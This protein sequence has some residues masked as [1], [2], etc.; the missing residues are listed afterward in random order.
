MAAEPR[1]TA[2]SA[3]LYDR[4]TG[5][6]L[7][8]KESRKQRPPASTTKIMTAVIAIEMGCMG[9]LVTISKNAASV[10]GTSIY[11]RP[12]EVFTVEDLLWGALLNSGNDSCVALAEAVAGSESLFIQM[13][14]KKALLVG[15]YDTTFKNT[16]GLPKD[17]HL[18]TAYDLAKMADYALDN[19]VFAAIVRTKEAEI[20]KKDT[21][22]RRNLNN[23]NRLLSSYKGA[24]GVKTGTTNAAGQCLVASATRNGRQLIAVVLKSANRYQDAVKILNHGFEDFTLYKIPRGTVV[25]TLYCGKAKPY[26]VDLVTQEDLCFTVEEDKLLEYEKR[27]SVFKPGLPLQ[28]GQKVGYLE[29]KANKDYMVPVAVAESVKKETTADAVQKLFHSIN[30][31]Y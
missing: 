15:A 19:P 24:D 12:G 21:A 13:M 4:E 28:A 25:G 10:G 27:L 6:I 8:D 17:G 31:D 7:F 14:N 20:P 1:V 23:T 9:E 11:L 16:N 3:I 26:Q 30:Q 29:I 22:W 18:S 2:P 5:E